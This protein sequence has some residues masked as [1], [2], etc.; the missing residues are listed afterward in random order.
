[1]C[2]L[3]ESKSKSICKKRRPSK[4]AIQHFFL[5]EIEKGEFLYMAGDLEGSVEHFVNAV[6][7]CEDPGKLLAV[8]KLT[9]PSTFFQLVTLE[10]RALSV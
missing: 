1:M 9:L 8:L 7:V 4:D 2:F 3:E 6:V 5:Q 10:I